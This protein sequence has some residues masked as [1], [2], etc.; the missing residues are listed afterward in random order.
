[1][2]L[3][4][5]QKL[6]NRW[7]T[8]KEKADLQAYLSTTKSRRAALDE[9]VANADT[10]ADSVVREIRAMYP[11][12]SKFHG[13]GY[14][15]GKR[16]VA[17][18]TNITANCMFLGES[19]TIDHQFTIWYRTILK[20]VHVTPQFMADTLHSWQR[21]LDTALSSEAY[22]LMK[23]YIHHFID[24]LTDFAVPAR[25]EVGDRVSQTARK[26]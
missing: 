23:P 11:Q 24:L 16:D 8:Q 6:D 19:E 9:I 21:H 25:P 5:I 12:F 4:L 18:L 13:S 7:P 15:K 1:M 22:S 3:P 2:I 26:K 20:S 14:E 17:L 10:V